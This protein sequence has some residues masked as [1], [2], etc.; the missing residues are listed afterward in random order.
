MLGAYP[1][2]CRRSIVERFHCDSAHLGCSACLRASGVASPLREALQN[3]FAFFGAVPRDYVV[4]L[5]TIWLPGRD[6]ALGDVVLVR[7]GVPQLF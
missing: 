7:G 4:A 3:L 6:V 5:E 1:G 2:Q